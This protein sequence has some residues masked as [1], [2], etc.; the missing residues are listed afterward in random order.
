MIKSFAKS[1][2]PIIYGIFKLNIPDLTAFN[3]SASVLPLNGG[4]PVNTI[5]NI[6]PADQTSH[7]SSYFPSKTSGAI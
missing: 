4:N 2:T 7:N 3:I 6:T 1:D 5:Y